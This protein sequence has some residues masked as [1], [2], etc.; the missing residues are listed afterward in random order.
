MPRECLVVQV[1]LC[2][3]S[4]LFVFPASLRIVRPDPLRTDNSGILPFP[5]LYYF[6][7]TLIY[8][9]IIKKAG[10][11]EAKLLHRIKNRRSLYLTV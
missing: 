9:V 11:W 6:K 3:A 1:F 8:S 7:E 4:F 10:V 2:I 5:F